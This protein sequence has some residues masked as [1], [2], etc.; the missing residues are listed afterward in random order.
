MQSSFLYVVARLTLAAAHDRTH[1]FGK[2]L[3]RIERHGIELQELEMA[4]REC[5]KL[6]SKIE[7][8]R[9]ATK[10]DKIQEKKNIPLLSITVDL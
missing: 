2:L 4:D 7:K 5:E 9:N 1:W 3:H 8:F 10:Q 6:R